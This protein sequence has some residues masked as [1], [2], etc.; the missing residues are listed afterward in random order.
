MGINH[1]VL[2]GDTLTFESL[3][4]PVGQGL[5][6]DGSGQYIEIIDE[7]TSAFDSV[8]LSIAL[9]VK[10]EG[11]DGSI[12]LKH[13]L[14]SWI[15][16]YVAESNV[17]RF[18]SLNCGGGDDCMAEASLDEDLIDGWAHVVVSMALNDVRLY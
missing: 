16:D 3:E 10:P 8:S 2:K 17:V 14:D 9:W 13:D 7:A 1:G 4:T 11:E 6:L 12:L 15:F 18:G 5:H